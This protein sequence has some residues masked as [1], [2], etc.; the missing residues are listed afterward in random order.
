MDKISELVEWVARKLCFEEH[1]NHP[2]LDCL[3][4]CVCWDDHE[5]TAKQILSHPDLYLKIKCP[6]CEWSQFQDDEA[7]GM[8]PCHECNSTGYIYLALKE[9]KK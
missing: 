2:C 3:A 4:K 8:T 5:A 9:A 1:E 7:V 6:H